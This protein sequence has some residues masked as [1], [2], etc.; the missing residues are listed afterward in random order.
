MALVI[1][2][3]DSVFT[4]RHSSPFVQCN[5]FHS[6]VI[7]GTQPLALRFSLIIFIIIVVRLYSYTTEM[8]SKFA[9]ILVEKG[10]LSVRNGKCSAVELA[11]KMK[12]LW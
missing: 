10:Q 1:M 3:F 4:C 7:N 8:C 5:R 9:A 2:E 12:P 11:T 6:A